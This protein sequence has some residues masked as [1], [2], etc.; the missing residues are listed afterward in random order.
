MYIGLHMYIGLIRRFDTSLT[1]DES[2]M[3]SNRLW[4]SFEISNGY[5]DSK[6]VKSF[7]SLKV[8]VIKIGRLVCALEPLLGFRSFCS[9]AL[10]GLKHLKKERIFDQKIIEVAIKHILDQ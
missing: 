5:I 6:S 1:S 10:D 2:V 8:H 3:N 7:R 4:D 9:G